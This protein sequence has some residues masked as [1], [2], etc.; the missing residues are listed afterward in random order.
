[1]SVMIWWTIGIVG[2]IVWGWIIYEIRT[3]PAY[4][5]NYIN[6]EEAELREVPQNEKSPPKSQ[7][8]SG[9]ISSL[10]ATYLK[11]KPIKQWTY[12]TTNCPCQLGEVPRSHTKDCTWMWENHGINY[13]MSELRRELQ[14]W[15]D[16]SDISFDEAAQKEYIRL[17]VQILEL[18]KSR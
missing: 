1:M 5:S 15:T 11:D 17:Q 9:T 2:M 6:N 16:Y 4:P 10:N 8:Y 12:A 14:K 18:E 3:S 7:T 13:Q